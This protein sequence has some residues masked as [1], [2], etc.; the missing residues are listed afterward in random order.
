MM[1]ME[2]STFMNYFIKAI[3]NN[4]DLKKMKKK[5]TNTTFLFVFQ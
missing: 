3:E 2:E 5:T 4:T 1:M